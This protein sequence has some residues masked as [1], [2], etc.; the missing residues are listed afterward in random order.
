VSGS[1][2][3]ERQPC[4]GFRWIGQ[5]FSSCDRC[6]LPFWKHS[7]EERLRRDPGPFGD[8]NAFE[9]VKITP[10]MAAACRAKWV[11]W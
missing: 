11:G 10:E 9:L 1:A 4:E 3:G 5:S 2:T 7:H 6:G 8:G